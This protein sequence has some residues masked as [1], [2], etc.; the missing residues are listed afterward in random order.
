MTPP[1]SPETAEEPCS[2]CRGLAPV[3]RYLGTS[4]NRPAPFCGACG[5]R[6]PVALVDAEGRAQ[7]EGG[8]P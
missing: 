3:V 6:L 5:R 4:E 7:W 8:Q 2:T 1:V